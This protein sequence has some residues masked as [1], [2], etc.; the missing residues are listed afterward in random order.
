MEFSNEK[1]C[2]IKIGRSYYPKLRKY[3]LERKGYNIEL[4]DTIKDSHENI[5]NLERR[6]HSTLIDFKYTPMTHFDGRTECF[7]LDGE[8]KHHSLI[9]LCEK[10]DVVY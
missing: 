8:N 1:E 7:K 5:V 10:Y 4:L 6:L 9:D 3:S 2:F